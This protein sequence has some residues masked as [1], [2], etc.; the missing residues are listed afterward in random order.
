MPDLV[1]QDD[2]LIVTIRL[3]VRVMVSSPL[4]RCTVKCD[5]QRDGSFNLI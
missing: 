2:Q 1:C 3:R 5:P 4:A